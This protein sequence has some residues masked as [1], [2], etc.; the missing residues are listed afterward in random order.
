MKLELDEFK[1]NRIDIGSL[2]LKHL[3]KT[4]PPFS[5]LPNSTIKSPIEPPFKAIT[6]LKLLSYLKFKIDDLGSLIFSK[7]KFEPKI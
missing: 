3:W 4:N 7:L 2:E 1:D 5:N 6:L